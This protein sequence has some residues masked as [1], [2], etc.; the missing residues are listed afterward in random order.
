[1][2]EELLLVVHLLY[3]GEAG[4]ELRLDQSPDDGSLAISARL[5]GWLGALSSLRLYV[6]LMEGEETAV[7]NLW[8][9]AGEMVPM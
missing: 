1:V 8:N 9:K 2:V 4:V 7:G 6:V 5:T 3:V